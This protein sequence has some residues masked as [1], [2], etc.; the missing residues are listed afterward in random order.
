MA[1]PRS[2]SGI[3]VPYGPSQP[4]YDSRYRH[5]GLCA[6]H[7]PN[8]SGISKMRVLAVD[9]D[10]SILAIL[11]IAV[12]RAGFSDMVTTRN[13]NE[14]WEAISAAQTPFQFMFL[15]I[16][17]PGMNGMEFCS[18]LRR[19]PAYADCPIIML[20]A[21]TERS[22]VDRAFQAGATGYVPKPFDVCELRALLTF[23]ARGMGRASGSSTDT[24][25]SDRLAH[26]DSS[27]LHSFANN[28]SPKRQ[29][30]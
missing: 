10:E 16:Q 24:L 25:K 14:A 1:C 22:Y 23:A 28:S 6:M 30:G 17:M 11:K 27:P 19:L 7:D 5:M 15:D 26:A 20:T 9:D 29:S 21:M 4:T 2:S 18:L 3:L 12:R 8:R 13:A